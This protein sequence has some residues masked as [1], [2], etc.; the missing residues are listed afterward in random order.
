MKIQ[1]SGIKR[2]HQWAV[3][4]HRK[5]GRNS[6]KTGHMSFDIIQ[7]TKY[8]RCF[9]TQTDGFR[10]RLYDTQIISSCI[11]PRNKWFHW[12]WSSFPCYRYQTSVHALRRVH[13]T[14]SIVRC[15]F[16]PFFVIN[17]RNCA[18]SLLS[19]WL[20]V[21][22]SP[23]VWCGSAMAH[24]KQTVSDW[25]IVLRHMYMWVYLCAWIPFN[26]FTHSSELSF[27]YLIFLRNQ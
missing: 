9:L 25:L 14:V 2:K 13:A 8:I 10:A 5:Y 24:T 7:E 22:R 15:V 12:K 6:Y 11:I 26:R 16:F 19:V 4:K 3:W 18:F 27:Y 23:H 21:I 1:N 17:S 20:C